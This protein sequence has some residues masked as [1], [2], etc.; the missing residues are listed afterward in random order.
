MMRS[1]TLS[2][3][4]LACVGLL[5]AQQPGDRFT[6]TRTKIESLLNQR[7]KAT[8]LPE[9]PANPFQ[10]TAPG[11]A[12]LAPIDP[13]PNQPESDLLTT[14]DQILAFSVARLR[15]SGLVWRNNVFH[16]L[17]N[18]NTY[19][20]GDLIPVRGAGEAVYY[21]RLMRISE[22]DVTFRYNDTSV[23]VLLPR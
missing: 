1:L 4:A 18:A 3:F 15:V 20:E 7:L 23:S 16:V 5:S 8:A 14:D 21:I 10:F 11:S 13:N 19:K 12:L 22:R 9:S 6:T 2:L 17:I